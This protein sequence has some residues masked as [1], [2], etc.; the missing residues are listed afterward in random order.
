MGASGAPKS[1]TETRRRGFEILIEVPTVI[2]TFV[3]MLH[4][5]A[6]ALLRS[7]AD[8][9]IPETLEIV[10]FWYLPIVAF[11]GF[12]VAQYR[13]QH[14]TTDL[15]FQKLPKA[16]RPYVLS[17]VMAICSVLSL[18]FTWFSF[19]EA[20]RARDIHKTAGVSDVVS[21][22]TYFLPVVAF[23][24]LTVLFAI[25]AVRAVTRPEEHQFVADAEEALRI[26]RMAASEPEGK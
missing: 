19:P 4:I 15:V 25:A 9:P 23:A 20:Q 22:P 11:L 10:Q 6:N 5:T 18:G 13:G 12:I 21:W 24:A 3:I 14:I 16:V 26:E 17:F 1:R 8:G 7:F 2:V